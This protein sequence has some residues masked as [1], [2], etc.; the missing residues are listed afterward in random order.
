MNLKVEDRAMLGAGKSGA[1]SANRHHRQQEYN[2]L[3]SVQDELE[4]QDEYGRLQQD[5]TLRQRF[6]AVLKVISMQ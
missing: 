5:M 4:N 6:L 1:L 2:K 3:K